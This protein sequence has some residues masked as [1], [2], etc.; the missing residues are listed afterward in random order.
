MYI[1]KTLETTNLMARSH[2]LEVVLKPQLMSLLRR[3]VRDQRQSSTS[4]MYDPK[5]DFI[6]STN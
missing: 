1:P 5:L 4:T 3:S 6:L 2:E